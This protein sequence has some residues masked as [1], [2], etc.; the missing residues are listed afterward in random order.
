MIRYYKQYDDQ[1]NLSCIGIGDDGEEITRE[2][3][4]RLKLEIR[5]NVSLARQVDLSELS[6]D[7]VPD[8]R[9]QAV[10]MILDSWIQKREELA[11]E[12]ETVE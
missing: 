1:G 2:E 4:E 6:M 7:D 8:T 3:Y 10:Q 5:E 9:R 11:R 12:A